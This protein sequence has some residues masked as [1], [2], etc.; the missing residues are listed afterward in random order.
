MNTTAIL[1]IARNESP[2]TEEWLE[3]HFKI[4][5]DRVY[6]VSTDSDFS[7]TKAFINRS[8]FRSRV[9][10]MHFNK[11]DP[12]WQGRCYNAHLPLIDED[13]I[14]VIDL[15]EFLYLNSFTHI[16]KFLDSIDDDVGQVQFPWLNIISPNYCQ[17]RVLDILRQ[18]EKH[19]SDHV[20]SI[21]RRSCLTGLGIHAHQIHQSKTCMSSGLEVSGRPRHPFLFND[22]QYY[23][24]NPFI[25]HFCSRGHFDALN[26]IMDHK[27]FN[28][29]S[30]RSEK[31]RLSRFLSDEFD[32]SNVPTRYMLLQFYSS[33]PTANVQCS[34]PSMESHSN[35]ND[36][37]EIFLKN[38]QN[39][40]DFS[41]SDLEKMEACFENRYE[42]SNKIMSQDWSGMF[43]VD[44]YLASISQ[45]AYI[46]KVRKAS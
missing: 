31:A 6:Y 39:V 32:W 7:H 18:A 2:F 5:I 8:K 44:D 4:G 37:K 34:M 38:I 43:H 1:C 9:E 25:L 42:F 14:L 46:D 33:L 17:D 3:Y 10:L 24:N 30:G 36:L 29:K 15:D 20:K 16:Q 45:L 27:F 11:F 40:V 13:W 22:G 12:G 28:A 21:V 23:E 26:R 19:V 35:V 41:Q